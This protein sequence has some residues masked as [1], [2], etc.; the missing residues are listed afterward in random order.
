MIQVPVLWYGMVWYGMVWYGMV[1][2]G[3]VW[4]GMVTQGNVKQGTSSKVFV[5]RTNV[6]DKRSILGPI[7]IALPR[8]FYITR[9]RHGKARQCK[10][11]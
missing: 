10:V 6:F 9:A 4:Y 2:Y 11:G 3:M 1:W 7:E 5:N 8:R